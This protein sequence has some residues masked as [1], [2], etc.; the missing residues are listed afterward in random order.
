[1]TAK[2]LE[3]KTLRGDVNFKNPVEQYTS[4]IPSWR[5]SWK[6]YWKM[7]FHDEPNCLLNFRSHQQFAYSLRWSF[8]EAR[9]MCDDSRYLWS[10]GVPWLENAE[11]IGCVGCIC[12]NHDKRDSKR[13]KMTQRDS[14]SK[15]RSHCVEKHSSMIGGDYRYS[16]YMIFGDIGR[17]PFWCSLESR[18]L[19]KLQVRTVVVWFCAPVISCLSG[20]SGPCGLPF[21]AQPRLRRLLSCLFP[22]HLSQ[23]HEASWSRQF[24]RKVLKS[25]INQVTVK[26]LCLFLE[27][28]SIKCILGWNLQYKKGGMDPCTIQLQTG[29][30]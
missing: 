9:P 23:A 1:M 19:K 20:A 22:K 11:V 12:V 24:H 2:A 4:Q 6:S 25:K 8:A 17:F 14:K 10:L 15:H 27:I 26:I 29:W 5:A 30:D 16:S 7:T 28:L 13:F 21:N 3:S 18:H